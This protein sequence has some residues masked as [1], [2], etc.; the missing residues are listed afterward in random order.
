MRLYKIDIKSLGNGT[1]HADDRSKAYAKV[2]SKLKHIG[3]YSN[4]IEFKKDV[5]SLRIVKE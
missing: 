2:Y 4:F 3:Y 5:L 1:V